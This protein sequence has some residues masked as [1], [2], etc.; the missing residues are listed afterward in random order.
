[1]H[2]IGLEFI[3][4]K[5]LLQSKYFMVYTELYLSYYLQAMM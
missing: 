5:V 1:M 2:Q 3:L 4:K